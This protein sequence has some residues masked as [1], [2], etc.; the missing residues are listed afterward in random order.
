M[1]LPEWKA[2][3]VENRQLDHYT[4]FLMVGSRVK[5]YSPLNPT[6]R[7]RLILGERGQRGVRRLK[8]DFVARS[9][10]ALI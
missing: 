2:S 1:L 8:T 5:H 10:H 4:A 6:F 7:R 9:S 3:K